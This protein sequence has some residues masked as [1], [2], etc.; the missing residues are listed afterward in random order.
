MRPPTPAVVGL[1]LWALSLPAL[2]Q[3][4]PPR[5]PA[6][7]DQEEFPRWTVSGTFSTDMSAVEADK[8]ERNPIPEEGI[9]GEYS[10]G[11]TYHADKTLSVTV[12][13]CVG[14]HEFQLQNAYVDWEVNSTWSFRAGRIPVPFGGF[15][16]R[17]SPAQVES[18]TKPLPYIMG[19]MVREE[20]FNMGIVPAPFIDNGAAVTG[21][22]WVT[23]TT[24]L[25]IEM[26]LVRGLKGFSP[27]IDFEQSRDFEDFN[28]EPAVAARVLLAADPVTAGASMTWGRYDREADLEYLMASVELQVRFGDW[29]LRVE[30]VM[31]ETDYFTP[32]AFVD[33]RDKESSRR[34]AYAVQIDGPVAEGWRA[35]ILHDYLKVDDIFLG[36]SGPVAVG[37]SLTTDDSNSITRIAGGFVY[38]V[39]AGLQV[40]GSVEYWDPS[41]FEQAIVLH[42]GVVAEY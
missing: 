29:N 11:T 16:R 2:A 38:S 24:K 17:T 40:K 32:S 30:G 28:G 14:C 27:D 9:T 7:K 25:T 42:L 35:F 21:T 18:G 39:R 3:S 4:E 5:K 34:T 8:H 33:P 31:R 23:K 12:R 20:P 36:P 22:F 19:G 26:A 10:L 6:A 1:F 13:A 37:S 41:D 15:T